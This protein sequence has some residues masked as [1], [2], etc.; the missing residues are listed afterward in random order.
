[1]KRIF[2]VL[3]AG[4]ACVSAAMAQVH[5]ADTTGDF[6]ISLSETL[7]VIQFFN[8]D[9][10]HCEDG[11]EDGYAPGTGNQACT[12]HNS[13]YL[14]QD[15]VINLSELLRLIQFFNALGYVADP[16]G[17]DGFNPLFATEGEGEGEGEP[18]VVQV[19]IEAAADAA[20]YEN[21]TGALA[22]GSGIY[23]FAGQT[24]VGEL[25]RSVIRFDIAAAIPAG[26][27]ILSATLRLNLSRTNLD[28][29][30]QPF[31]LHRVARAW[32]EGPSDAES[33]EGFGALSETGD[34]TW[35]HTFYNDQ[36]WDTPGGDFA[37]VA[38][39]TQTADLGGFY[40]WSD[41]QLAADVQDWLDTPAANFGW[42]LQGKEGENLTAKRFDAREHPE[43]A[44]RPALIVEYT[45]A[46]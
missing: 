24:A 44:R 37:A 26:A 4:I 3:V 12:P 5:S 6:R 1:M 19:A 18:G 40:T 10:L 39:A 11:T 20:L 16:Q 9:T 15:W 28:A 31:G 34:T 38:S 2:L 13:D 33:E 43:A 22:N 27:S 29:G 7:R 35:L 23:L 17:E 41:A 30:P 32:N 8:L 45:A 42:L 21:N 36:F 14:P 25:R 46:K